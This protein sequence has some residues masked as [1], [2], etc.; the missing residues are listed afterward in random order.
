GRSRQ[1]IRTRPCARR[2]GGPSS[3]MSD[4]P[5]A[6]PGLPSGAGEDPY[7]RNDDETRQEIAWTAG[8]LRPRAGRPLS[9][10]SGASAVSGGADVGDHVRDPFSQD[11]GGARPEDDAEPRRRGDHDRRDPDDRDTGGLPDHDAGAPGAAGDRADE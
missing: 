3:A 5:A 1:R 6:A 7:G 2:P 10:V 11:A 4:V 9:H 8:A